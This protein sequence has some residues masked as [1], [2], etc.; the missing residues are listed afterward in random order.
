MN[1]PSRLLPLLLTAIPGLPLAAAEPAADPS[2]TLWYESPATDWQNEAL[3]IG[4][5]R[6]GAMIFG[7]VDRERI[8]LNEESVWSGS[9]TNWN[10]E[11]ASQ[12][13]PKIRE[14]LLA[15]KNDEAEAL[16]NQTFTC[17][18]GG[19]RGGASGPWGC[20]QELGNLNIVWKSDIPSLP[21]DQWQYTMIEVPAGTDIR[22]QR[23]EMSR[24]VAE[25]VK[26]GADTRGWTDYAL[27]G[28]KA[29][30][31][32]RQ[33]VKDDRVVLRHQ[34][35]LT[36][37]QLA[38]LGILRIDNTARQ[39]QVF[40][41]GQSAG[42][43]PGWQ[44]SAHRKFERDIRALLKP[45][46]NV[47][48][49][50]CSNYRGRGQLP[51][52]VTLDPRAET[53][54]YRRSLDLR[55]AVAAVCYE[56]NGVT[57]TR[58]AFAS[59]PDEV[60]AFRFAAD[61][62]GRISFSATLDRSQNFETVADGQSGL[63]MTGNTAS[64]QKDVEGLK[65]VARLR[66]VSS[67]GKVSVEGNILR[68]DSADEVVLLVAAATNYQ[69]FAG[70]R[71]AD[72]LQATASDLEKA[73]LKSHNQLRAD[74]VADHRGYFD[75]VSLTL[76]DGTEA[77]KAAA[78]LPT[79]QRHAAH[80]KGGS[81]PA[82][83]ALYFNFGRYLLIGSSRPGTMPANLQG[84]WAEGI[85]TPWNGDY[86]IDINVQM[87]YWPAEVTGLGDCHT[88]L[89]KLIES[90]Q[91]PGAETA[92]EYYNARGW[93]AHVIT[94]VW[95]F[96]APGEQAGWGAT[97]TGT[98]WLCDHLW[99]HYDYNRDKEFLS[100]AYPIM[101]G[102]AEFFLD[103]LI[104]DP[105]TGWLVTAPSNSPENTLRMADGRTARVCM[106]PT[107]DMQLLRE[108]FS[109]CIQAAEILGT[110][111]AFRKKLVETRAKLAPNRI[112]KHGQIMEW[113]EDYDEPEPTHRHV[114]NL[115]GLHPHDEISIVATPELAKAARVTLERRGDA[116]TGWS[117]AWKSNFWA[118]LHDG[119]HAHKLLSMLIAKGG[120]N[121]FCLHPPFQI[122]GNFGGTAAIAEMLLQS[123]GGIIH[124]LPA[125]PDAWP[126]G[127]ITGLRARGGHHVDMEWKDG[128]V[129][130]Y[131]IR[132]RQ[133][134]KVTVRVNG[135]SKT[136]Q[137]G[138]LP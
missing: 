41:N 136:I 117:M 38:G 42:D 8:A 36:E 30:K 76:D 25:A 103:M 68:V 87:N 104:T 26:P 109:N 112:G 108:L 48:A 91:Q 121:L 14:L 107:H 53:R 19:S 49:I 10:R 93:V 64:G 118:R 13:L 23:N 58:E 129:V 7:G 113:L 46:D 37:E 133:P 9:R 28:G 54:N 61:K 85:Q 127:K 62:P 40:V 78:A 82:L 31:G 116:S 92:R 2:T 51:V 115:Y 57:F 3:P 44:A 45:G 20:F 130:S 137:P 89:F 84:I 66:A 138:P 102:A 124:L 110:D 120:R 83:A 73:M 16:V 134:G 15:G 119:N 12:N 24:R 34:L 74:S 126:H 122:D 125:L 100:Y 86:H 111:E 4:N 18:G 27:A 106:G 114:S 71:T 35:R 67:G 33:L 132:S 95:G 101:K 96:T 5:G 50:F 22:Q 60:M 55:E 99:E 56:S 81:D 70:R 77:A 52:A 17:T 105:K 43:L 65:F 72:P 32:A 75:R 80:A 63:L 79:D 135:E 6:I 94:N 59:A 97:A 98:A 47:I 131:Q 29:V 1:P 11:K 21:L 88:P 128:K 69:G 39:G 90:L 123:H